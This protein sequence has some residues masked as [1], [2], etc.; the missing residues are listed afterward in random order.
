MLTIVMRSFVFDLF[1]LQPSKYK[2]IFY[3]I[4]CCLLLASL[5]RYMSRSNV[6]STEVTKQNLLVLDFFLTNCL[7]CHVSIMSVRNISTR[8]VYAPFDAPT[9]SQPR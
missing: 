5:S 7:M 4:L 2:Y 6:F 8:R 9:P 1:Y 3:V